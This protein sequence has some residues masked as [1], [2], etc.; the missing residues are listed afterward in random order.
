M[1]KEPT[2]NSWFF[3]A[4]F[5]KPGGSLNFFQITRIEGYCKKILNLE[6]YYFLI[7]FFQIFKKIKLEVYIKEPPKTGGFLHLWLVPWPN[8]LFK[9]FQARLIKFLHQSKNLKEWLSNSF[10]NFPNWFFLL[11]LQFYKSYALPNSIFAT[12]NFMVNLFFLSLHSLTH[13]HQYVH[14]TYN[15]AINHAFEFIER[16]EGVG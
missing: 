16:G 4:S 12:M 15:Y 8:K 9:Y 7:I 3:A 6:P 5:M 2:L 1:V 10:S 14:D 11:Y 13:S